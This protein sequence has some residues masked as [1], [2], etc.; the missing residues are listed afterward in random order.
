M[1]EIYL[2]QIIFAAVKFYMDKTYLL[3]ER[4]PL[5]STELEQRYLYFKIGLK[6][7]T[8]V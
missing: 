4:N 7:N 3:N 6:K 5:C 1:I 8:T 2:G